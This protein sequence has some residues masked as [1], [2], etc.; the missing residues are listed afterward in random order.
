M[1]ESLP[2]SAVVPTSRAPQKSPP[3]RSRRISALKLGREVDSWELLQKKKPVGAEGDGGV[4]TPTCSY[5]DQRS[6]S[7]AFLL[8]QSAFKEAHF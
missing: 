3:P 4:T 1:K 6:T 8:T 2:E 7:E 5:K